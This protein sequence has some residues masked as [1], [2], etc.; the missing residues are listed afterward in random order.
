MTT[1]QHTPA[2]GRRIS[3]S[4]V[5]ALIASVI[6][7]GMILLVIIE[8]KQDSDRMLMEQL[9]MEKSASLTGVVHRLLYK[10]EAL[11][12]LVIQNDGR[13]GN[14]DRVASTL[15]DDPAIANVLLAPNGVVDHVYPLRGNE[16]V[17]GLNFFAG[18]AGNREAIQAKELGQLVFGGPFPL[19]QGG[20]ALVGRLPV[21]LTGENGGEAGKKFWGLVSVTLRFPEILN[22]LG[23][24]ALKNQGYGYEIWRI[25]PDTGAEQ[26]IAASDYTYANLRF[27]EK[28]VNILNAVWH[29]RLAPVKMW[30][31]YREIWVLI[32]LSLSASCLVAFVMQNN[33]ELQRMH[34]RLEEMAQLDSLTGIANRRH[35]MESAAAQL[36]FAERNGQSCFLIMMDVDYFKTIND[37][38]GH[39][40]GDAVLRILADRVGRIIRPCDLFGRYGGEEFILLIV[41]VD[42]P[43]ADMLAERIRMEICGTPFVLADGT[44]VTISASFGLSPLAPGAN[45]ETGIKQ[46]DAALYAAKAEGRNRTRCYVKED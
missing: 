26:V 30:Y 29:F 14:F 38:R 20:Q 15:L 1:A 42:Q 28:D 25:N 27:I 4:A 23:L 3:F 43:K 24:A 33:H 46:A 32:F 36:R 10:T 5:V 35:F 45:L 40:A 22:T 16:A 19:V 6:L 39:V 44:G 9:I 2:S 11:A 21:Y 34:A 31:Y 18:G 17:L 41:D 13:V 12:A 37:T 8:D 7:C